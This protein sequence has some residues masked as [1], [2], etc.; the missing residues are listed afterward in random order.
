MEADFLSIDT[1]RERKIGLGREYPYEPLKVDECLISTKMANQ[2]R[3]EVGDTILI[4]GDFYWY[5]SLVKEH[6]D[7]MKEGF[8]NYS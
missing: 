1:A 3:V 2:L 7:Y 4:Q 5:Y 6:Y 8:G